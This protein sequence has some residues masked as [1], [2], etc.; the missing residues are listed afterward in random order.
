MS[1]RTM[2]IFEK[3]SVL[4]AARPVLHALDPGAVLVAASGNLYDTKLPDE[5][6]KRYAGPWSGTI[7]E[8]IAYDPIPISANGRAMNGRSKAEILDAI[9][10]AASG[11]GLVVV[12]TDDDR[13]GDKI[14]W[15]IVE[16]CLDWAGPVRR[17][18]PRAATPD[19]I[20]AAH[21]EMLRLPDGGALRSYCGALEARARQHAD[22][23]I[24]I[25]G[26]RQASVR[27]RPPG[28]K[29][30]LHYG[31]VLMPTLDIL[32]EREL[33]IRNFK[34]R[35]YF[36]LRLDVVNKKGLKV[37]LV[38]DPDPRLFDRAPA[39][40]ILQGLM[41]WP[42]GE[43]AAVTK[44]RKVAP[45]D[46]FNLDAMQLAA[47]RRLG[48]SPAD[49]LKYAQELYDKGFISYPRGTGTTLPKAEAALAER[50]VAAATG[51]QALAEVK[52][53][54]LV[55][56]PTIYREEKADAGGETSGPAHFAVVPTT[57]RFERGAV[58]DIAASLYEMIARRF[59]ANHMPD[60]RDE[61]TTLSVVVDGRRYAAFGTIEREAGW[62]VIEPRA[63][64]ARKV[65]RQ[66]TEGEDKPDAEG[67]LPPFVDGEAIVR[68]D[69]AI[70]ETKTQAPRRI[71]LGELPTI[72]AKL[73]DWVDDP[74]LKAALRVEGDP[75]NPKGLGT[76]ATRSR[77]VD[78]LIEAGYVAKLKPQGKAKDPPLEC[79][80]LGLAMRTGWRDAWP[81]HCDPVRRA[82]S[83]HG[84]SLIGQARTR[85]EAVAHVRAWKDCVRGEVE[86]MVSS[87]RGARTLR[88]AGYSAKPTEAMVR[89]AE[90]LSARLNL[91]LPD[92]LRED[93]A[94]C[95]AFLDTHAPR[96]AAG[97]ATGDGATPAQLALAE[98]LAAERDIKIPTAAKA[99]KKAMSAWI[100]TQI[101]APKSAAPKPAAGISR[102]PSG[103]ASRP[104]TSRS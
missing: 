79:L 47:G 27:L 98:K 40:D 77:I 102:R 70:V 93:A 7:D 25:N 49:T 21:A 95:K 97:P 16:H 20:R 23:H 61:V 91:P 9:R 51:H 45:P 71:T 74:A 19:G 63:G 32:A 26:T 50:V 60:A 83:E 88:V 92:D 12:A 94:V 62:R 28:M 66:A 73:I 104:A 80:E 76:P 39:E 53:E 35:D 48:L 18:R 24:G 15:D 59:I 34:P 89:F 42:G 101:K 30:V 31:P 72:M 99:S 85:A 22:W 69:A 44:P 65:S 37:A 38:H 17:M 56:R 36:K 6:D 64:R 43:I 100:D 5:I 75:D 46:L 84:L 2:Y 8:A 11:C 13:E 41:A 87:L 52:L 10:Q 29:G 33:E 58:T 4:Q 3:G 1:S 81:C 82:Q 57:T 90:S 54:T 67:R 14:G 96:N 78:T 103:P 68:A 55:R 86:A